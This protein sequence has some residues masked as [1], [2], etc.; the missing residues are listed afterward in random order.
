[1]TE[2]NSQA[3]WFSDNE[4]NWDDR[5]ELHMAGNYCDY[6]R[7]LEDPTPLALNWPKISNDS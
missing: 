2:T 5:A 7:L 3:Q 4:Q 6:Q 1:M